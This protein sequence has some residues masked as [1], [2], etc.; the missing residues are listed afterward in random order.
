[1]GGNDGRVLRNVDALNTETMEW[2][3]Y[4]SMLMRRDEHAITIGPDNKI[5]SVGG[6]GGSNK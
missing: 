3:R 1:V 4:P 6:Y 5:Y 2:E